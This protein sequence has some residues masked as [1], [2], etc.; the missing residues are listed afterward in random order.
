ME[1]FSNYLTDAFK[2]LRVDK[3]SWMISRTL[4]SSGSRRTLESRLNSEWKVWGCGHTSKWVWE[5]SRLTGY[6]SIIWRFTQLFIN[7][8]NHYFKAL[9]LS[10]QWRWWDSF[11]HMEMPPVPWRSECSL[12]C[13]FLHPTGPSSVFFKDFLLYSF[14]F[15]YWL[16]NSSWMISRSKDS[17]SSVFSRLQSWGPLT[18]LH[19][20]LPPSYVPEYQLFLIVVKPT[21]HLATL[22]VSEMCSLILET[23]LQN[24]QSRNRYWSRHPWYGSGAS[25]CGPG[26]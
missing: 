1:K 7:W 12:P 6:L 20:V 19:I 3:V 4:S 2:L 10:I 21:A 26:D 23:A 5:N 17:W 9:K 13:L 18:V 16:V 15:S 8:A 25:L 14:K 24:G 11:V 22:L